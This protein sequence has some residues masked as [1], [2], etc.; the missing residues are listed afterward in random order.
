MGA[1]AIAQASAW[2]FV[3]ASGCHD[4]VVI[5]ADG[6]TYNGKTCVDAGGRG[7]NLAARMREHLESTS[8]RRVPAGLTYGMWKSYLDRLPAGTSDRAADML[9]RL[10]I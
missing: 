2:L 1:N 4:F 9:D 5:W 3:Q 8:G 10:A 7:V 6:S